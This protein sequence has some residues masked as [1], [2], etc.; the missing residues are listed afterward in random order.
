MSSTLNVD[1]A[2]ALLDITVRHFQRFLTMGEVPHVRRGKP[3]VGWQFD[4]RDLLRWWG[5]KKGAD[6]GEK[7]DARARKTEAEADMAEIEL[8]KIKSELVA[9]EDVMPEQERRYTN[10][11]QRFLGL[12][13]KA[14]PLLCPDDPKRARKILDQMVRE[15]LEELVA[16]NATGLGEAA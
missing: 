11:R 10:I 16:D 1:E 5:M 2:C 4:Q 9:I 8:A 15:I 7:R 12:P 6:F 13:S 3:G 14:A